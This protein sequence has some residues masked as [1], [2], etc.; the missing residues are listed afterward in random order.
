MHS[1]VDKSQALPSV[2]SLIKSLL[3]QFPH[4]LNESQTL[5]LGDGYDPLHL[6][7]SRTLDG[8]ETTS[9]LVQ[10]YSQSPTP[11]VVGLMI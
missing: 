6:C 11:Y 1:V 7:I 2:G 10:K 3:P 5:S 9:I 4:L 8:Y